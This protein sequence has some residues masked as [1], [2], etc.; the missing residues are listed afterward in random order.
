MTLLDARTQAVSSRLG[1]DG[2]VAELIL[3]RDVHVC[4]G[5]VEGCQIVWQNAVDSHGVDAPET[6]AALFRLW[7]ARS[8]LSLAR[9]N[10]PT[11]QP[12]FPC[13]CGGSG[14]FYG[15]GVVENGVFRGTV[16]TCFRCSGKGWQ[17]R[18]DRRR[19]DYYDNHV[20]RISA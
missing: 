19:N 12:V 20:R 11:D 2:E 16:G 9:A 8:Y 6:Q 5:V 15:R 18:A 14:L 7:D 4:E 3:A 1:I 17:S 10:A 13:S